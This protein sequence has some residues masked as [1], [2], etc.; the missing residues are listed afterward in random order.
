MCEWLTFLMLVF[1]CEVC[2]PVCKGYVHM[3]FQ[4]S[5]G[6]YIDLVNTCPVRGVQFYITPPEDFGVETTR[7]TEG[8]LVTYNNRDGAVIILSLE[9]N[10]IS[11]GMGS[12]VKITCDGVCGAYYISRIKMVF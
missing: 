4:S 9:G 3:G 1:G 8:F 6:V 12:I 10:K 2:D 5:T 7:R 11:P